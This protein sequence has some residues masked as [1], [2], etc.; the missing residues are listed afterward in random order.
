[1]IAGIDIS[2]YQL[3]N[4]VNFQ[5]TKS[6]GDEFV[7]FKCTD[8]NMPGWNGVDKYFLDG[9]KAAKDAGLLVGAYH[10]FRVDSKYGVM[11]QAHLFHS[12][13]SKVQLDLPPVLDVEEKGTPRMLLSA[14]LKAL[15]WLVE[16]LFQR[17]PMI[18]TGPAIWKYNYAVNCD[19]VAD[20]PL[21]IANYKVSKPIV[22]LPW[23]DWNIWQYSNAGIGH[24]VK[25]GAVDLNWVNGDLA[26]LRSL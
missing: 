14:R 9:V 11:E 25:R 23:T 19:W 6:A 21:W 24:G 7:I 15:V 22:P 20:Y 1:M 3:M 17:K 4:G 26:K 18:Y 10:W 12:I 13:A 8:F 2:H 16:D 5:E